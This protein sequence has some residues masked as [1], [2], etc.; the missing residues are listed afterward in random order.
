MKKVEDSIMRLG[1]ILSPNFLH[2]CS[3]LTAFTAMSQ[4]GSQR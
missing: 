3:F 2:D 4:M 1:F